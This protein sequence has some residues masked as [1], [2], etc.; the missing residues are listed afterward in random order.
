MREEKTKKLEP[1]SFTKHGS[2]AYAQ[3]LWDI[4]RIKNEQ[5][6]LNSRLEIILGDVA[7]AT[8]ILEKPDCDT[9]LLQTM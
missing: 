1:S 3:P 7:A 8:V 2:P 6:K 9:E 4:H 5:R